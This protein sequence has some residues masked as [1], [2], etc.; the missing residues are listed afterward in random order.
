MLW[1]F[2]ILVI[3]VVVLSVT[4]AL[5]ESQ[6]N[7]VSTVPASRPP[8]LLTEQVLVNSYGWVNKTADVAH[9]P[10]EQAMQQVVSTGWPTL[11]PLPTQ[12]VTPAAGGVGQSPGAQLFT[13]LGCS[14]CHMEANGTIAPTLHGVYGKPV[15]LQDGSTVTVDDAYIKE[16]ILNPTAKV[17]KGFNPI[18]PSFQDKVNDQ[19]I[20]Q[21][22]DYIKSLK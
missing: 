13:Q 9:I 16:S 19:Q 22:I 3:F 18:M 17:V 7:R 2:G 1:I 11:K 21:L 14:G 20:S 5:L 4:V 6:K 8:L 15:T 12:A 10:V